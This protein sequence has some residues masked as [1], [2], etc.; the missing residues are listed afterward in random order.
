MTDY[1]FRSLSPHDFERLSTDL[2]QAE[3]GQTLESFTTG[4]DSG[5]DSRL[6]SGKKVVV[7]QCKH[8]A[9]SPFR[10]LL[11]NIR[12]QEQSRI[13]RL[14]AKTRYILTTSIGLT[15]RNKNQL[16]D[17]LRPRCKSPNDIYGKDD[18][19]NLLAKHPTIEERHYKLWL[20]S[21]ATLK[22]LINAGIITDS[23]SHLDDV[24]R[25]LSR[26]VPNPSLDRAEKILDQHHFCII[27]GMPGIGKTT[28]AEVLVAHLADKHGFSPFRINNRLEEIK[29]IKDRSKKQVFYFDDF[30]GRT[31]LI[32]LD[33]NEDR[34]LVELMHEVSG[35]D[36]WRFVLTTRE[37]ILNAAKARYEAIHQF[38]DKL[39]RCIVDLKDYTRSVRAKILYNHIHFS[40]MPRSHKLAILEPPKRF[41]SDNRNF[42]YKQIIDHQ[43]YVPRL[44]EFMTGHAYTSHRD[45]K[46]Y[47][48]YFRTN[49]DNPSR[50]WEH[51]FRHQIKDS[52]Q[53]LLL[54][55]ATLPDRVHE[56]DAR[57]CFQRFSRRRRKK[58]GTVTRADDCVEALREL[59]GSFV[60]SSRAGKNMVLQFHNPS[61]EDFI[62]EHLRRSPADADDLL[63]SVIFFEQ[64]ANLWEKCREHFSSPDSTFFERIRNFVLGRHARSSPAGT[65]VVVHEP[66]EHQV[67]LLMRVA[68][69]TGRDV[70]EAAAGAMESMADLWQIRGGTN[71]ACLDL[72]L[73]WQREVGDIP[74]ESFMAAQSLILDDDE[75]DIEYFQTSARFIEEFGE[76]VSE[77][78]TLRL[79]ERFDEIWWDF[80]EM[81]SVDELS[82]FLEIVEYLGGVL[83]MD[84]VNTV[85]NLNE[86]IEK[87]E[88]KAEEKEYFGRSTEWDRDDKQGDE[89]KDIDKMFAELRDLI[90]R[91]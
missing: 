68:K 22:R 39:A 61:V 42:S 18:L 44:I 36:R 57:K 73:Y 20:T 49:L 62:N 6:L 63:A 76:A 11:S 23:I 83:G 59:D 56:S 90:A 84:V 19:N 25:R 70:S 8:F 34:H 37:Y 10:T 43:N 60:A 72:L 32:R 3:L 13:V 38:P 55:L 45:V 81:Q 15:P 30:L 5:I 7:I 31:D 2:L 48:A 51:A 65:S 82:Y 75:E 89:G 79:V 41:G 29:S 64:Y 24:R 12:S 27:S 52:S 53:R 77:E 69:E 47:V 86:R 26:Y 71:S 28:L 58:Y 35:N 91:S 80:D 33:R 14:P 17:I 16:F 40:D 66:V 9:N 46:K 88:R 21:T 50:I 67:R 74:R 54:V 4:P 1:D 85:Y 78:A 87:L